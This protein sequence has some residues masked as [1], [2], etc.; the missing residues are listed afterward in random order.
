MECRDA[1]GAPPGCR[2]TQSSL[3]KDRSRYTSSFSQP[4]SSSLPSF[5]HPSSHTA[6]RPE[7]G[8]PTPVNP[9]RWE[10][11]AVGS[12]QALGV[13]CLTCRCRCCC[14]ISSVRLPC[15]TFAPPAAHT[16]CKLRNVLNSQE[17]SYPTAFI[18]LSNLAT[19][20]PRSPQICNGMLSASGSK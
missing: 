5:C 2:G 10:L 18:Q 7:Y 20:A 1:V 12:G 14:F 3:N 6:S 8:S 15:G 11:A 13:A 19:A 17:P 16:T 9:A 4:N